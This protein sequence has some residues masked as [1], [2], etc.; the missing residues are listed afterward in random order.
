MRLV[1]YHLRR[2]Y[3]A[4]ASLRKLPPPQ[5]SCLHPW[6]NLISEGITSE[7]AEGPQRSRAIGC[8]PPLAAG[9][10][11]AHIQSARTPASA[12]TLFFGRAK[13]LCADRDTGI[14]YFHQEPRQQEV[15]AVC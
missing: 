15:L 5:A 7:K 13:R 1:D 11:F 9:M 10:G 2:S 6:L 4:G 14:G 3:Q 12:P 8:A